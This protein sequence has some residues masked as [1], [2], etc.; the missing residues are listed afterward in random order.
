MPVGYKWRPIEDL[1]DNPKSLTDGELKSLK[2]VWTNQKDEMIQLGT[3]EEFEKRLR[4]E[5]S[6]ET[7]IIEGVY[8]LDRGVTRTL[9]V[10]GIDAAFIPHGAPIGTLSWSDGSFRIITK[11]WKG[12][13]PSL[14][15]SA[16]C[17]PA[18]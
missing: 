8:T 16:N 1:G 4:R 2:R 5:W 7:G 15:D 10:K 9:I 12:C 11:L 6:I 18:T 17:Q 14:V 13:S 3:L